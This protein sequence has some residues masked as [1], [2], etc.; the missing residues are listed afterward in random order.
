MS[1]RFWLC[2]I[3]LPL[4]GCGQ[5]ST[6]STQDL[7]AATGEIVALSGG[8]TGARNAC[9]TCHGLSG[10]GNAAG[11]PRLAGMPYGYLRK[12][13]EDYADGRRRHPAMEEIARGLDHSERQAVVRWYADRE[14]PQYVSNDGPATGDAAQL[15]LAGDPERGLPACAV[16]HGR[17]GE[18]V[19]AGN[20]PLHSQPP[21]YLA[22][23][24]SMWRTG[25]RQNDASKVMLEVS[26]LL[27]DRETS[28]LA[29]YAG[30]LP[31][32]TAADGRAEPFRPER[33]LDR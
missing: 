16:C 28:D 32:P 10:E 29:V 25:K 24:L 9:H 21:A 13:M 30:R 15:W 20:P 22:Q 17:S 2:L 7:F 3:A 27:T 14:P 11:A 12:Q 18:G 8:D 26:Q 5:P 23:Q 6:G 33:Y 19:G 1:P 31:G 4:A